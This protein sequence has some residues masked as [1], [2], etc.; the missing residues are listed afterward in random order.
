MQVGRLSLK[1]DSL[2]ITQNAVTDTPPQ[3]TVYVEVCIKAP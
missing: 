1:W 2:G 3:Q